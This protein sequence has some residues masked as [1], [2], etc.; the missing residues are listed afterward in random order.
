MCSPRKLTRKEMLGFLSFR[1]A[2]EKEDIR[3]LGS[4]VSRPLSALHELYRIYLYS[5]RGGE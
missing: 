2:L 3:E 4:V 1:R 5:K